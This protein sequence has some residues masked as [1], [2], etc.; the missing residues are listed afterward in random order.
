MAQNVVDEFVNKP[1]VEQNQAVIADM[2]R[3]TFAAITQ[4][5]GTGT[6]NIYFREETI[7]IEWRDRETLYS[8]KMTLDTSNAVMI[9]D[10]QKIFYFG[11]EN[12]KT[13]AECW[14]RSS[15]THPG[16]DGGISK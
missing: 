13:N 16:Y 1:V 10:M 12:V 6:L 5:R 7:L 4:L 15:P 3:K 2:A 14:I 9:M 11:I 8:I